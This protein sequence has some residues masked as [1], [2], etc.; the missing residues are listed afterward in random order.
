MNPCTLALF[1]WHKN[2]HIFQPKTCSRKPRTGPR[3]GWSLT[4]RCILCTLGFWFRK[5]GPRSRSKSWSSL[6]MSV[7]RWHSRSTPHGPRWC[8]S[9]LHTLLECSCGKPPPARSS[10]SRSSSCGRSCARSPG[11]A[12]MPRPARAAASHRNTFSSY[13]AQ[14]ILNYGLMYE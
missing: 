14:M 1:R 13:K 12:L 3:W 9:N 6:P 7:L 10:R 11:I 2:T 5:T 8:S 4:D